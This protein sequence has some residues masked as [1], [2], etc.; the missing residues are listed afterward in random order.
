MKR[1]HNIEETEK[2]HKAEQ[3]VL[4]AKSS[5]SSGI[6][7][8]FSRKKISKSKSKPRP[9]DTSCHTCGEKRHWTLEYSKKRENKAE[10]A[11][12]GRSTHVAIKLFKNWEVG[13]MLMAVFNGHEIK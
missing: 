10:Q 1:E 9:A 6:S 3:L 4:F 11:K 5:S 2:K 7:S 12:S 13:K 8:S